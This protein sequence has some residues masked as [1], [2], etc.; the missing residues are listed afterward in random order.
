VSAYADIRAVLNSYAN[1]LNDP[2]FRASISAPTPPQ[3]AL[4]RSDLLLDAVT[5][6]AQVDEIVGDL[7]AFVSDH[8]HGLGPDIARI[9]RALELLGGAA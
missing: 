1:R 6:K 7:R 2:C 4:V 3:W 5:A 9:E 8:K